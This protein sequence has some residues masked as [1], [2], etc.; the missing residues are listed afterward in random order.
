MYVCICRAITDQQ[1]EAAVAA[2]A[3]NLEAIQVQLG[4]ATGCGTCTEYTEQV[5]SDALTLRLT[6]AV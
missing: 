4:A 6:Y 1:I 2:G 3:E 5:I